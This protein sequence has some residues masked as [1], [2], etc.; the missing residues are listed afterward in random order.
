MSTNIDNNDDNMPW[1]P[2][3]YFDVNSGNSP[4]TQKE[5]EIRWEYRKNRPN[6]GMVDDEPPDFMEMRREIEEYR[7]SLRLHIAKLYFE[8]ARTLAN[9][10]GLK[11]KDTNQSAI[12]PKDMVKAICQLDNTPDNNLLVYK[13]FF[14]FHK[15]RHWLSKAIDVCLKEM[16]RRLKPKERTQGKKFYTDNRGGF[17]VVARYSKS[18]IMSRFMCPLFAKK[19]WCIASKRPAKNTQTTKIYTEVF[20]HD[21]ALSK[22]DETVKKVRLYC[23]VTPNETGIVAKK[24]QSNN[25]INADHYFKFNYEAIID[26]IYDNHTVTSKDQLKEII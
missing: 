8:T 3:N 17:T 5:L 19:R 22:P 9:E 18:Q 11:L 4:K 24:K 21:F 20:E 23:T 12:L 25:L 2:R 26:A 14:E 6:S 10:L 16:N 13:I 7:R 1:F 15:K